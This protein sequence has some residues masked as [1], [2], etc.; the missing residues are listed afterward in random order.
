[1]RTR[2]AGF[3]STR[4]RSVPTRLSTDCTFGHRSVPGN[5]AS[6]TRT[7]TFAA[8]S[9]SAMAADSSSGLIAQTMPA[10]SPPQIT[11]CVSGRFGRI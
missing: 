9:N 6:V 2:S 3:T 7:S 5:G 8:F 11:K 4:C 10:A 1:M